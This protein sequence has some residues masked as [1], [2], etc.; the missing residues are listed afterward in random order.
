VSTARQKRKDRERRIAAI[1]TA[2]IALLVGAII[3]LSSC[4]KDPANRAIVLFEKNDCSTS[5]TNAMP[6]VD[7]IMYRVTLDGAGWGSRLLAG[8]FRGDPGTARDPWPV[9]REYARR[10]Q[11]QRPLNAEGTDVIAGPNQPG[12][13]SV[14][15]PGTKNQN[16]AR[17]RLEVEGRHIASEVAALAACNPDGSIGTGTRLLTVLAQASDA[18]D[19]I[20][21]S[22]AERRVVVY[23]DGG[24]TR[25][26]V[27]VRYGVT[28][29]QVAAARAA[30]KDQLP[31]L[32]GAR[33]WFIGPGSA[34]TIPRDTLQAIHQLMAE[35]IGDA[36]GTLE[37]FS[38]TEQAYPFQK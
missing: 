28:P 5:M 30:F 14:G 15:E 11:D 38:A 16:L 25:D 3:V 22:D 9:G 8:S 31:G 29:D 7:K 37:S 1:A 24:M 36:G 21:R 32:K 33:V 13:E 26:G 18:L 12:G 23:T 6:N 19:A 10:W 20:P 2:A 35:V 27:D 4:E 17:E 34:T